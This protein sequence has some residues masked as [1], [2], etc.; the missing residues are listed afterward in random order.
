M[1]SLIEDRECGDC[2][3][4][5]IHTG[6]E[7]KAG[8]GRLGLRKYPGKPCLNLNP[9]H[10]GGACG[11]YS[12]RPHACE[13]YKCVWLQG[14][15]PD[16]DLRPDISGVIVGFYDAL[17]VGKPTSATVTI[18]DADKCGY[19]GDATTPLGRILTF[20][21]NIVNDV[22]VVNYRTRKVI[23]LKNGIVYSGNLSAKPSGPESLEF[24]FGKPVGSYHMLRQVDEPSSIVNNESE[25]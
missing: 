22:K 8:G 25:E 21:T 23:Y 3:E 20:A 24:T 17:E 7:A 12:R 4:C 13:R 15:L 1:I 9:D 16:E 19:I 2:F 10:P 11:V 5:C 6:I 14:S 18:C